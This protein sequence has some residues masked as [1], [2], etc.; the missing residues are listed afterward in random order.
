MKRLINLKVHS[1]KKI[2]RERIEILMRQA[3]KV[4]SKDKAL[5]K[6]YVELARKIAMRC[7]MRFP[8]K[9]RRKVCRKCNALLVPGKNCRIRIYKHR[10]IITCLECGNIRRIPLRRK[11]HDYGV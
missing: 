11:K 1:T 4:F 7:A 5:A 2:A 3:E 8:K 9:W 6:R 10:I